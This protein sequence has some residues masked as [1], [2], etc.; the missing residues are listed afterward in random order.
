[1]RV[2]LGRARRDGSRGDEEHT[3]DFVRSLVERDV[4]LERIDDAFGRRQSHDLVQD[5][6][7]EIQIHERDAAAIARR[8]ARDVPRRFGGPLEILGQCHERDQRLTLEE[9]RDQVTEPRERQLPR[10]RHW[11][12]W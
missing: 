4:V 8:D 10:G 9:R 7:L 1:V 6:S 2:Q 11:P 12:G 3:H 5:G